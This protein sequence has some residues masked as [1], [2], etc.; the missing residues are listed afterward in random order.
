MR[1]AIRRMV[2]GGFRSAADIKV[3]GV[4]IFAEG[5]NRAALRPISERLTEEAISEQLTAQ[6]EWPAVTDCDLLERAFGELER[7]GIVARQNFSCCGNCGSIEILTEMSNAQNRGARVRGY[8]FY[9][10]QDTESAADGY[11]LLLN[12]GA[13]ERTEEAAMRIGNEIVDALQRHGLKTEW[14]GSWSK[15]IA[16][17]LDWKRRFPG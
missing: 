3:E 12:Y 6:T 4:E 1:N 7:A 15:R 2:A 5:D 13:I 11:G 9:H 16:V 14:D 10:M 17:K 8:A